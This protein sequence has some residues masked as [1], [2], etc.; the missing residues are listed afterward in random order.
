MPAP[1]S[2]AG[3]SE[4]AGG[5]RRWQAFAEG[6]FEVFGARELYAEFLDLFGGGLLVGADAV[7]QSLVLVGAEGVVS[8][9]PVG[10]IQEVAH[11]VQGE[12]EGL[13]RRMTM[14]R[15]TSVS[16]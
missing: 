8:I 1:D 2:Q 13:I 4:A 3:P 15:A 16:V 9:E 14:R 11:L 5:G 12:A 10:G 7:Q 6:D